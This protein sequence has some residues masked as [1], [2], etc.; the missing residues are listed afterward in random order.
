LAAKINVHIHRNILY[1]SRL[2]IV[3]YINQ[4]NYLNVTM[5]ASLPHK[6]ATD[7]SY[8]YG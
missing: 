5:L 1:A 8:K 4:F 7:A 3:G 6:V 2:V